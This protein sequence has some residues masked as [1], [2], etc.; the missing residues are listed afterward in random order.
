M[1]PEAKHKVGFEKEGGITC[2]EHSWGVE[3]EREKKTADWPLAVATR[4]LW[5]PRKHQSVEAGMMEARSGERVGGRWGQRAQS[6]LRHS[7]IS[8]EEKQ[9]DPWRGGGRG[10]SQGVR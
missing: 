6:P 5:Q 3:E 2:A 1:G 8:G 4:G 10:G 7:T 9:G